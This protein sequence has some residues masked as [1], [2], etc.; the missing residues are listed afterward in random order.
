MPDLFTPAT[1]PALTTPLSTHHGERGERGEHVLTLTQNP[2]V[3]Q[4]ALAF[5]WGADDGGAGGGGGGGGRRARRDELRPDFAGRDVISEVSGEHEVVFVGRWRRY[6]L[7]AVVTCGCL[8]S[9]VLTS[10]AV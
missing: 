6:V 8:A 9:R 5:T 7:S 2:N 4:A 10:P 1:L 3:R